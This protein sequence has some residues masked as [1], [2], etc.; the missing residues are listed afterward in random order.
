MGMLYG[1][2]MYVTNRVVASVPVYALR[3]AYYTNVMGISIGPGSWV[4]MNVWFDDRGKVTV[5]RN[6]FINMRCRLDGRGG[7]EIGD[8]VSISAE[9]CILTADHDLQSAD[10]AGRHAGVTIQDYVFIGTR[11]LILPGVTLGRGSVVAAG[12]VVSRDVPE[13]TIVAGNPARHIGE[14]NRDLTYEIDYAPWF[15]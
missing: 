7:I 1:A 8:N 10:L 14:R 3:K 12:A 13:F 5:G 6:S 15:L 2:M 4:A 9:T 11:A